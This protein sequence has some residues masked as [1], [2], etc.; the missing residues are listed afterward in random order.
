M[1]LALRTSTLCWEHVPRARDVHA[2]ATRPLKTSTQ[3]HTHT[4]ARARAHTHTQLLYAFSVV[5]ADTAADTG[6]PPFILPFSRMVNTV[7]TKNYP[8]KEI[9]STFHKTLS[10]QSLPRFSCKHTTQTRTS[11]EL[12]TLR[13]ACGHKLRISQDGVINNKRL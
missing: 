5:L 11:F 8:K 3:S 1:G 9:A 10:P 13:T 6:Q 12:H 7:L 2:A 4:R